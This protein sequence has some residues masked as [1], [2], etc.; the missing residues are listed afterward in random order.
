[1]F[2][3]GGII[4]LVGNLCGV[5]FGLAIRSR[6]SEDIVRAWRVAHSGITS[7]GAV[8]V[9]IGA[10]LFS[11]QASSAMAA[12]VAYSL[13]ISGYGFCIALPLGAQLGY[14]GLP[15]GGPFAKRLVFLGNLS[16]ALGAL[17]GS[18]I[19]VWLCLSS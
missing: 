5:P 4:L 18:L 15:S 9:A 17:V 13:I 12:V 3:H 8:I 10:A 19:F 1:M 7:G 11:M 14:R 2:L 16:G 6:K